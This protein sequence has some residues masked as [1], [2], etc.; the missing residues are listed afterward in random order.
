MFGFVDPKGKFV[1][2]IVTLYFIIPSFYFLW[3][4]SVFLKLSWMLISLF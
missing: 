3:I 4:N 2:F 1:Y